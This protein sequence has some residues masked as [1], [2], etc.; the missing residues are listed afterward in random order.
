MRLLARHERIRQYGVV[1]MG[2]GMLFLGM[3]VMSEGMAPLRSYQPFPE[4]MIRMESPLIGIAFAA[5]FTG[6]VQSSSATTGIIIALASQGFITLPAGIALAF[7]A[8]VGTCVTALFAAIGKPREAV[9]AAMVHVLFNLA[10]VALWLGL[11]A[12]L[13]Q[14]VVWISPSHPELQGAGRL[15][16]E[17]PRQIANAHT[18]F[19][20]VNTLVF[21]GL[22]S[23]IARLV[24]WLIPDRPLDAAAM[25]VRASYLDAALL[26]TP[27][28]ALERVRLEVLDIGA[29]VAMM[30]DKVV[31][32]INA[33]DAS[34]LLEVERMD[35]DV[36]L[37]YR[38]TTS[39]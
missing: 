10:G 12:E 9:R 28:L 38:Q 31:P 2:L 8:N 33:R 6:L 19:N 36:D 35:D 26:D 37:L 27:S 17:T 3:N 29:Q 14:V 32:A 23:Q 18:I 25:G 13:A 1:L 7:G 15:A 16:A 30:L 21:I 39:V 24:E 5:A 22:T 34:A 11:I 20:V 4:L